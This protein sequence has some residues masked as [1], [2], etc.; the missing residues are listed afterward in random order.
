MVDLDIINM[1][2]RTRERTDYLKDK[3]IEVF[4][5]I[6]GD[7]DV[8][9]LPALDP[10]ILKPLQNKEYKAILDCGGDPKGALILRTYTP[11][12]KEADNIFVVNV[13]RP[14][15]SDVNHIISYMNEIEGMSGQRIS[16][17]INTTH[18]LKDTKV[19]DVLKGHEIVKEVSKIRNLDFTLDVCI[20]PVADEI[21]KD[22][23][24]AEEIK[25]KIFPIDLY[26]RSD[27]MM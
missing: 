14:E 24:I 6:R 27:W 22:S 17:I 13:N 18:M 1:Y 20:K 25:E 21:L 16:R 9:D 5:S 10:A 11:Y 7:K 8:L 15:T 19:S 26:F 4:S 2:F 23:N 12:L 3:G